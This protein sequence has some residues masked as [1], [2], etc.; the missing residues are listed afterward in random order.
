MSVLEKKSSSIQIF[1]DSLVDV[2]E[3]PEELSLWFQHD[4]GDAYTVAWSSVPQASE[5]HL[6][7]TY[8]H[9]FWVGDVK[10][11]EKTF[12]NEVTSYQAN[13]YWRT[14]YTITMSYTDN[15]KCYRSSYL[16]D[17]ISID[18]NTK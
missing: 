9:P 14:S 3:D 5:Y 12:G 18:L 8:V 6:N 1:L 11:F 15:D 4:K 7:V 13:F 2:L 10:F 16:S 17:T